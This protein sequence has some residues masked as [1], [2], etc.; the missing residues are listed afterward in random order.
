MSKRNAAHS[1]ALLLVALAPGASSAGC[2][3]VYGPS[4]QTLYQSPRTPVPM[5]T[6]FI[7]Q[8]VK[9]IFPGGHLVVDESYLCPIVTPGP[10][11]PT[12]V[13]S[14]TSTSQPTAARRPR[15]P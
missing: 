4:N 15:K 14:A 11:R 9:R 3:T 5:D 2:F 13:L 6:L 7:D 1:I 10:K 8:E 12:V